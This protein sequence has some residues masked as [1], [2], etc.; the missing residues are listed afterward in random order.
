MSALTKILNLDNKEEKSRERTGESSPN[1]GNF[2]TS[3]DDEID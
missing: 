1:Y 2:G 3:A